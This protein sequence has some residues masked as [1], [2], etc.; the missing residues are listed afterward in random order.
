M[1]NLLMAALVRGTY[2][3]GECSAQPVASL[4]ELQ[5]GIHRADSPAGSS[6]TATASWA[7]MSLDSLAEASSAPLLPKL[8]LA[9]S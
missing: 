2:T 5:L 6:C 9:L 8:P 3:I 1:Q 4:L 7:S